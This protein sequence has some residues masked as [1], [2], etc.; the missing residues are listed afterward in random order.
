MTKNSPDTRRQ[1]GRVSVQC[2]PVDTHGPVS[3]ETV[4]TVSTALYFKKPDGTLLN[5]LLNYAQKLRILQISLIG[6]T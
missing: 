1:L 3:T 2:V 4:Q 5:I 6:K